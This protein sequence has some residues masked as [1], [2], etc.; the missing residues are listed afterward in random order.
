MIFVLPAL[1]A[2]AIPAGAAKADDAVAAFSQLCVGMFT[3]G[4]SDIDPARFTVTQLSPETVKEVKPD[5]V[6][7]EVWDVSGKA[8]DVHLLVHY[9]P[10]GMCVVEVAD[11]DESAIRADYSALVGQVGKTLQSSPVREQDRIN[12]VEGEPATTSMWRF[13][14]AKHDIMLAITTYPDPKFMI[15]HLMTVSYVR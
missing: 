10:V 14:T 3:G 13:K 8:S 5:L 15:Q 7:Q 9:E 1:A 2:A 4:K 12:E 6:G 11:A